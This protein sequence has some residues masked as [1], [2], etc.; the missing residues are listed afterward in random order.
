[1]AGLRQVHH[2]LWELR[3]GT[4]QLQSRRE[5][6][7]FSCNVAQRVSFVTGEQRSYREQLTETCAGHG[8][9][10]QRRSALTCLLGDRARALKRLIPNHGQSLG[11]AVS[12]A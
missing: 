7:K 1:M 3:I 11:L 9:V 4:D 8:T 6:G 10:C 5:R 12:D 2:D